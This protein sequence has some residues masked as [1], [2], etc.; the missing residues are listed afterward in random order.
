MRALLVL[1][2]LT[3]IAN[4]AP[5]AE[6]RLTGPEIV[7]LLAGATVI[8]AGFSQE[9]FRPKRNW[10]AN[11]TNKEGSNLTFGKW[12]IRAN[13][14]CS[15]WPPSKL[16]SCYRVTTWVNDGSIGIAWIDS[17]GRRFEGEIASR[18]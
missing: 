4:P 13:Q 9:F 10:P 8:G 7:N 6:R 1:I 12:E 16:W 3:I 5:A 17:S 2:L 15:Q 18:K 14:Y 11:T